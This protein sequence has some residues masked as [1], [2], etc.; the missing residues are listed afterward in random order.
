MSFGTGQVLALDFFTAD[1]LNGTEVYVPAAIEYGTRRI[2]VLTPRM[3]SVMDRWIG[4]CRRE[5]LDR[6][7]VWNQRHLMIV[8]AGI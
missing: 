8:P 4:S 7:L 3:N 5:L 1:L 6:T 2:R